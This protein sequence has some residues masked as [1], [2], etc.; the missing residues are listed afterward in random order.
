MQAIAKLV[1]VIR[2]ALA[3]DGLNAPLESLAAE[4]AR[5]CQEANNRLESCAVMLEKG[6]EYQALQLAEAEPVL[7]DLVA[8]L[9]FAEAPEWAVFCAENQLPTPV[10]LDSKAVQALDRLYAKGISANHPLYKDYRAAVTSRDDAKAIRIIRSIVRLNPDD[11]NAKSE[12]ARIENK[13]FQVKLQELRTAL[14]QRDENATLS[15]LSELERLAGPARLSEEPEYADACEVR[16]GVARREAIVTAEQLVGSLDE[17]RQADG[18][19]RVGDILARLRALQSE[20]GFVLPERAALKCVVMQEYFDAKRAAA[21]ETARFEQALTTLGGLAGKCD[22]RLLARPVL[23]I[24]QAQNSYA[25]LNRRW[26]EVEKF[27][28]PVPEDFVHRV[29]TSADALRAELDRL[30]RQRRLRIVFTSAAALIVIG[31]GAWF[32]ITAMRAQD[33]T[34]QLARLRSAGQVGASEKMAADVRAEHPALAVQPKLR[35]R[36]DE[37]DHWAREERDKLANIEDRLAD[38]EATAK[39]G[40][41]EADPM[42]LVTKLETTGQLID[43]V[44]ND[45]RSA[46]AGRLLVLRNQFEAHVAVLREKLAGQADG[47]LTTLEDLASTRLNYDQPREALTQALGEMEPVLKSLEARV[48]PAVAALAIPSAQQAR[49]SALR[50]RADLFHAEVDAL[51]KVNEALLQA[52]TLEAYVQA[53]S[54]YK[55]SHLSQAH[56][57]NDAC[58]LLAAFPKTD[59]LLAGLLCPSDPLGWAAARVDAT[60]EALTPDTV[61]P[62]E[63][64]KLVAIRDDTYL[65]EIWEGTFTDFRRRNERRVLYS[66]GDLKKEGPSDVAGVQT[67]R[68]TGAFYDPGMKTELPGFIPI[69]YSMQKSTYGLAGDGEVSAQHLSAVSE[70]LSGLELNRMT[71][72][73]G[74]KFERP[75]LRVFD[76]LVRHPE[77]SAV[78]KAYLMQ[79]LAAVLKVRPYAWGWEYCS[80]LRGDLEELD[81]LCDHTPLRSQD[82]LLERK[83][84]QF[85]SKLTAFFNGLH[86]RSYLADAQLDREV[87]RAVQKAG[88]QFAGFLDSAG[89]PHLLGEARSSRA[90]WA[91][92]ADGGKLTRYLPAEAAPQG[93]KP[94]RTGFSPFSSC[95]STVTRF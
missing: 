64:G 84:A 34:A 43:T 51:A 33:Y 19:R 77:A 16:R 5:L 71:D 13:L 87:V 93:T 6:S 95:P 94:Q 32:T 20:N 56:E 78:F 10:K 40:M 4:Y 41:T 35:A 27:Q 67:T 66:R 12:L 60:G 11:A 45:L 46:P 63:M 54:G 42:A 49:V 55:A 79:Q 26:V 53:L 1:R 44:A 73:S 48:R 3:S 8:A 9:S 58:K 18:W 25:E 31:V 30:Q 21:D 47:E 57:V 65:N 69:T 89:Q 81:R 85:G 24:D 22:S 39:A 50:K 23:T 80:S 82:W 75:L 72:A 76:D 7:L 91:L 88:L 37:V 59:D 90:L 28:R 2:D 86:N 70:C 38:L 36:L 17:E 92:A 68:W 14:E 15:A 83:R 61:L 52:T 29:R 62:V 74:S